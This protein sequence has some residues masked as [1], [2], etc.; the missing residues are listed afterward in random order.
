MN[1]IKTIYNA[2]SNKTTNQDYKI[3]APTPG[4]GFKNDAA[5][6]GELKKAVLNG[7]GFDCLIK[8][9]VSNDNDLNRVLGCFLDGRAVCFYSLSDDTKIYLELPYSLS[10]YQGLAAVQAEIDRVDGVYDVMPKFEALN[11]LIRDK[12]TGIPICTPKG[13]QYKV[14]LT[15]GKIATIEV[16]TTKIE[17]DDGFIAISIDDDQ[18]LIGLPIE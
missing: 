8:E 2:I 13:Y 7:T 6:L 4:R 17:E 12:N 3:I 1:D 14:T 5:A 11:G 16:S 15:D 18:K 9:T 10:Q